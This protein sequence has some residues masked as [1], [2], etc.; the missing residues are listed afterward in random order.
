[1]TRE[2]AV[3]AAG[4]AATTAGVLPAFLTGALGVQLQRD[5]GFDAAGLGAAVGLFFGAA[6][7]TSGPA[8]ALAE[9][10]GPRNSVRVGTVGS[11]AV[12]VALAAFLT[13]WAGLAV[14]MVLAG[15]ANALV[16]PSVNA[17]LM[18]GA[19]PDRRGLAFGIKQSGVPAA[20]LLGGAAVPLLALTLGWRAAYLAGAVVGVLAATALPS[21]AR[22]PRPPADR[23]LT[24]RWL[25][26][27]AV[28]TGLGSATASALAVFLVPTAVQAGAGPAAAGWLLTMGSL[29]AIVVRI[30]VGWLVDRHGGRFGTV[31]T[32]LVAGAG[33]FALLAAPH[34]VA[35]ACGVL[36]AFG[37]GWGWNGLLN[38]A[39][40]DSHAERAAATTGVTQAAV[41][42]GA[43]LG[44]VAFGL[45]VRSA[46]LQR[47]WLATSLTALAAGLLMAGGR[48]LRADAL[49]P[50]VA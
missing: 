19:A 31:A 16:Q 29:T 46:G 10:L 39:V 6:A 27:V 14:A 3:V 28:A 24:S 23:R 41:Y 34:P 35:V 40:A 15:C 13:S 2:P 8:G 20:T 44:P 49:R 9:L 36:V 21:T 1:L 42:A 47:A 4:V 30:L 45:I 25:L 7:V 18:H 17:L 11:A 50:G 33:G 37:L 26:A 5:L 48:R 43:T 32:M 38:F 12:Q 22:P